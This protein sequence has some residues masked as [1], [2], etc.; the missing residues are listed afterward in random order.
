MCILFCITELTDASQI[1]VSWLAKKQ[2]QQQQQQ[3]TFNNCE[4]LLD[5]YHAIQNGKKI[6]VYVQSA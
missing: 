6:S 3:T 2:Q 5:S 1:K 4:D